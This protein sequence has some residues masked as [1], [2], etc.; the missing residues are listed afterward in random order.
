MAVCCGL[1]SLW[2]WWSGECGGVTYLEDY[3][4]VSGVFYGDGFEEEGLL[5]FERTGD[6]GFPG[7]ADGLSVQEVYGWEGVQDLLEEFGRAEH[8]VAS[9]TGHIVARSPGCFRGTIQCCIEECELLI[10]QRRLE[11]VSV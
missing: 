6:G 1:V 7:F 4:A 10:V 2:G 9:I 3:G 5:K 11:G 8:C